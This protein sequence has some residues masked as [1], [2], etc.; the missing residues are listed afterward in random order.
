VRE[1]MDIIAERSD[2]RPGIGEFDEVGFR[3]NAVEKLISCDL[4]TSNQRPTFT[5]LPAVT[6]RSR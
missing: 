3:Q 1:K 5:L 4:V 2:E 6:V